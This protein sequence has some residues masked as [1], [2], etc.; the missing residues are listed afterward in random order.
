MKVLF[1]SIGLLYSVSILADGT[2]SNG[3]FESGNYSGWNTT[4]LTKP[5]SGQVSSEV[6]RDGQWA[7]RIE[8]R[9]GDISFGGFRAE[10]KD[11][12]YASHGSSI[13]Y[14]FGIFIPKNFPITKTN[15]CVI[16]QWHDVDQE[17][18]KPLQVH[19]PPLAL[20]FRN[21]TIDATIERQI[22]RSDLSQRINLYH[23]PDFA[24]GTWQ[25]FEFRIHWSHRFDGSVEILR[26]GLVVSRYSGPIG[27][28]PDQLSIFGMFLKLG[29]YCRESPLRPLVI[30]H[31]GYLR[32]YY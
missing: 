12:F 13:F 4:R 21:G 29:L 15:S 25:D 6:V 19:S 24:L 14:R 10:I 23:E 11:V 3:S 20:R 1:V 30:F 26:N 9:Q 32:K 17:I 5:Y 27:F 28:V 8:L 18:V 7:S 2:L 31:D 16:A 22:G